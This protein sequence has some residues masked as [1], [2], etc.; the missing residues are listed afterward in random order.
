MKN[1]SVAISIVAAS[2]LTV[3]SAQA[4][5]VYN[6]DSNKLDLYGKIQ[7]QHYFS[8]DNSSDGD[9]TYARL[10]FKGETQIT[11][12]VTGFGR[13]EYEIKGNTP[14]SDNTS[15]TRLAFAGLKFGDFGSVD[16][17]RNYGI[18]YDVGAWTDVL[19]EFGG[20]SWSQTDV[21]MNQRAT[22]VATYRNTDFF[23]L[24]DGL[25]FAVQYQG[26][27]DRDNISESNGDGFGVS[28]A[29]NYE[30]FGIGAS[31]AKSDRTDKQVQAGRYD[32]SGLY[33]SGENAEIWAVG[34]KYDA[35]DIYIAANYAESQN[36]GV[37]GE[38]GYYG[39]YIANKAQSFEAVAQYQFDFGLRPSVAYV[40]T[41]GKDLG[42]WGEQDLLEYIDVAATYY[43]NRNMSAF[44]EYKINLID[45]SEFTRAANIAT[46]NVVD[47]GIV[48]QF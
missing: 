29:Y 10:G 13:W 21:F 38:D 39:S 4:A 5:E 8:S 17:G 37:F 34:L 15:K 45:K 33:A 43:F 35:N 7:A 14:E 1:L 26:K 27:N 22:G 32:T 28:A 20:D 11:D 42:R 24:V 23:G 2:V 31:Y 19:P 44:V 40:K 9:K 16:Y 30:G 12:Q 48:Y 47:V 6:K 36:M 18:T 3:I 41:R 25:N 46:D